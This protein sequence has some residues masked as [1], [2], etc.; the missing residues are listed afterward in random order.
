MPP[1]DAGLLPRRRPDQ[2]SL[3]SRRSCKAVAAAPLAGVAPQ[4]RT[5]SRD[6]AGVSAQRSTGSCA[7][8]GSTS[9]IWNSPISAITT[10]VSRRRARPPVLVVDSHKIAY[11]LARQYR[12][13]ARQLGP[14]PLRRRQLA[15]TQARRA[16]NLSRGRR[17][18]SLQRRRRAAPARLSPGAA[19]RGDSERG[20]RRVLSAAPYRSARRRPY[21]GLFRAALHGAECRWR[22]AFRPGRSGRA[23]RRL[24]PRARFKIIGSSP[25]PALLALAGPR[26]EFTG[27]VAD[28]RPHLAEAAAVVV[29]L[30]LGG[31]TRLKIVEA[32]AMGKAIVSTTLGAEGIDAVHGRDILIADEPERFAAAVAACC[33]IPTLQRASASRRAAGRRTLCLEC[34]RARTGR[35]LPGN[36]AGLGYRDS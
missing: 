17:R 10:C 5:P 1:R 26:V 34:G 3:W 12:G 23:S 8:S 25:P 9:S 27:F 18:L 2:Q 20:G 13:R 19:D 14:P 32:M 11:D 24:H 21:P 28:L 6:G 22:D 30:R 35:L 4:L 36:P 15:Q 16:G 33:P 31:G 29:P 7:T